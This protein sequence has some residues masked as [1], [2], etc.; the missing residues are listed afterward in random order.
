MVSAKISIYW[1]LLRPKTALSTVLAALGGAFYLGLPTGFNYIILLLVV[2]G[3]ALAHLSINALNDYLDYR[4]GL[5]TLTPRTPFSGGSK[6]LVDKLLDPREALLLSLTLLAIASITGLIITL[7]RG[8]LILILAF[9]GAFIILTYN[10]LWVKIA[11]GEFMV[12]VKGIL[13]FLGS[14]YAVHGLIR[15]DVVL[16]GVVYGLVSVVVLYA[17]FIPDIEA[18]R[19]IGRRTIPSIL[20]EYAWVGYTLIIS[21]LIALIVLLVVMNMLPYTSLLAVVPGMLL[22]K[23]ASTLKRAKRLEDLV[24]SLRVNTIACRGIDTLITLAIIARALII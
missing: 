1:K 20:G 2:I 14:M 22:F 4:S 13:V 19:A 6:V 23:V 21:T 11:L 17:N 3:V 10:N 8:L 18:D 24:E 5:D 7:F 15:Y 12:L 16:V 9:I